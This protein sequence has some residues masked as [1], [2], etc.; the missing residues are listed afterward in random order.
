MVI[1]IKALVL[2]FF[3]AP[4]ITLASN[5]DEL[6]E[7]YRSAVIRNMQIRA[8]DGLQRISYSRSRSM[9]LDSLET[10]TQRLEDQNLTLRVLMSS[11]ISLDTRIG[12][13]SMNTSPLSI[14]WRPI[15]TLWARP[16]SVRCRARTRDCGHPYSGRL[17]YPHQDSNPRRWTARHQAAD[18]ALRH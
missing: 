17:P 18:R 13:A 8:N 3:L 2:L 6:E 4:I 15:S 11:R 16:S 10:E 5:R 9:D 1:K 7:R 14:P 12:C